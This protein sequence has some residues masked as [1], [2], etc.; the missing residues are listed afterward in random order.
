M[1]LVAQGDLENAL[2]APIVA[3]IFDDDQDGVADAAP[4]QA[5]C[6]WA[7]EECN[8]VLRTLGPANLQL[9]VANPSKQLKFIATDFA[10][11]YAT[12]RRPDLL[13][14]MGQKSW[15]DFYD[16]VTKK[17]ERYA[18]EGQ[19]FGADVGAAQV[20]AALPSG[21]AAPPGALAASPIDFSSGDC[22]SGCLNNDW[23]RKEGCR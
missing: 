22:G 13:K 17:M 14:A 2:G 19:R 20:A 21:N 7:E 1:A 12:R 11:V 6:D 4:I 5:C 3:A 23:I 15:T 16:V 18:K 8:A 10:L 9:P